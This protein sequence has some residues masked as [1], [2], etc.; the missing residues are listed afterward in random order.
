MMRC[1]ANCLTNPDEYLLPGDYITRDLG[2]LRSASHAGS[3]VG[4]GKV[5]HY[6]TKDKAATMIGC[7]W[8]SSD[9]HVH[10]AELNKFVSDDQQGIRILVHCFQQATQ[11][12]KI[13]LAVELSKI[14]YGETTY[15]ILKSNCQHFASTVSCGRQEMIDQELVRDAGIGIGATLV[16]VGIAAYGAKLLWDLF[17]GSA[18]NTPTDDDRDD[19][20]DTARR[21][22]P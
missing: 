8:G 14:R 6:D 4:L 21:P 16:G 17:S 19:Q 10:V 3:Y 20:N 15:G 18:Y 22:Q 5:V 11:R 12:D 7:A 2:G 13:E 9:H 1:G